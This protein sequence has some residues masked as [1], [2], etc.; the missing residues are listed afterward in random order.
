M[1]IFSLKS[2]SLKSWI[3][4]AVW[5][6]LLGLSLF[7]A[8]RTID[9]KHL[10]AVRCGPGAYLFPFGSAHSGDPCADKGLLD[11]LVNNN[12]WLTLIFWIL[13]AGVLLAGARAIQRRSSVRSAGG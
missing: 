10:G 1:T 11:D 9:F 4:W 2:F 12:V 13:I 7:Y 5:T 3:H 6:L 8:D